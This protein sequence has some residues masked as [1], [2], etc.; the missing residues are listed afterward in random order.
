MT[1]AV[2]CGVAIAA[3][4]RTR[5]VLTIVDGVLGSDNAAFG[6]TDLLNGILRRLA[7]YTR[8]GALRVEQRDCTTSRRSSA[9]DHRFG[10]KRQ[11]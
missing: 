9:C 8:H 10:P 3:V 11:A 2:A 4:L 7:V 6:R 1:T 5:D